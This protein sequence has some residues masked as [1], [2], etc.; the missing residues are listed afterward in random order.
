MGSEATEEDADRMWHLLLNADKLVFDGHG[1]EWLIEDDDDRNWEAMVSEVIASQP[2]AHDMTRREI[3]EQLDRMHRDVEIVGEDGKLY[4]CDLDMV[5]DR[6]ESGTMGMD[7][8]F[9]P[10]PWWV[11]ED[12]DDESW[13]GVAIVWP[14]YDLATGEEI[15]AA[16]DAQCSASMDADNVNG[17]FLIDCD[18]NIVE[19]GSW[20]A[21]Q[22]GVRSVFV[23]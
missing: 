11:A 4:R 23:A 16:T 8:S 3:I 14:L 7:D 2:L 13:M 1:N 10:G 9:G 20:E 22:P 6:V 21:Q 19:V 5:A 18:G 17:A 12:D 15:G